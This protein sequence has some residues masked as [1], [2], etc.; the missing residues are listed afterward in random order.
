M[1]EDEV[2]IML[3]Q[4]TETGVFEPFEGKI[5]EQVFRL[6]DRKIGALIT[7]R[8]EIV[9]LDVTDTAEAIR[10]KVVSSG[11]SR[12]PVAEGHL[13][14]VIGV[15]LAK[16]LLARSLDGQPLDIRANVRPALFVPESMPALKVVERF[17][18]THSKL[19][20]V[21]DEFGGVEGLVTIDDVMEA[22]VGDIP[23]PDEIEEPE[24]IQRDDGSWLVDGMFSIDEFQELFG[25]RELP[26]A[27]EGYYQ[28][29]GGL[30]MAGLGRV[31]AAGDHFEWGGLRIEV[32]DMDER[33]VDKVLVTQLPPSTEEAIS[34]I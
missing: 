12:F 25:L 27:A 29:V 13:D 7:P 20:L 16:D 5:V 9:W 18:E 34:P 8:P 26:S 30:V 31:P 32:L 3:E 33:R 17:K 6:A 24:A 15:V 1:T 22:I 21:I 14:Q 28:T 4:G 23:E 2:R 11:R 19:A 10:R